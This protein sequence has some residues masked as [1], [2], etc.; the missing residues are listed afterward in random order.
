MQRC[1]RMTTTLDETAAQA[2]SGPKPITE[3]RRNLATQIAV[4][5]FVLVPF[6]ALIAAVPLLWG[7]GLTWVDVAL[8]VLFFYVSG[9]GVTIGYHRHFTHG[10][11]KAKRGMR[12]AL[13]IAGSMA[14]QSPPI[15]WVA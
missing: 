1:T 11:F 7:W 10:S 12:I 13:A 14:V 6:A 3:G 5:V 2:E 15:T 8:A 9:L 4:Y